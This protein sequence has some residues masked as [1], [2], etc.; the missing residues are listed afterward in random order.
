MLLT[1]VL[2]LRTLPAC[3]K[4]LPIFLPIGKYLS[5]HITEP[6]DGC[7][8]SSTHKKS[9]KVVTSGDGFGG[10]LRSLLIF[11]LTYTCFF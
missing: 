7:K 3:I 4:N 2:N 11:I 1:C 6:E 10:Y 8:G 5:Y 9:P